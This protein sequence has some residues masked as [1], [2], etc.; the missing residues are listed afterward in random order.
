MITHFRLAAAVLLVAVVALEAQGPP[1]ATR[2]F[3]A[4]SA[5]ATELDRPPVHASELR[6]L[7]DRFS[8]DRAAILRFY[9]IPG[10][11][12][13]RARMH[14]FYGGWQNALA[15]VNFDGL[16][17]EGRVDFVLLRTKVD[18][19][20]ALVAREDRVQI[21][22]GPLVPFGT[23]IVTLAE[24]RQRLDFVKPDAAAKAVADIAVKVAAA[25]TA[26]GRGATVSPAIAVR[27]AQEVDTLAGALTQWFN[28]F[29]GYDPGF[30]AA[31]PKPYQDLSQALKTYAATLREKL[32]G[33]PPGAGQL[34]AAGGRGAG[35]GAPA[36]TV[37][38]SEGPIV[39]DPIG[40]EGLFEDLRGEMIAYTPEQLIAI[41]NKEAEWTTAEMKRASR[42]MGFGDDWKK[43]LEKVKST[44]VP[45]GE[46]PALVR[47]LALQAIAFVKQKDLVTI[48]P[49]A[50]DMWRMTMMAPAQMRVNPY[51]LGGETIQ[52]S[53]PTDTMSAEDS[54]M[55]MRG[56]GPH[57]SHATVFHE[58]IPGH[59]LQGF[60][61]QRYNAHRR[62]FASPFVTEGWAL[63]WEYVM[64]D[65]GFQVSPEDRIGALFWRM[66][67]SARIVFSLNF[68]LGR[69]TPEQ[70]VQYL[71]DQVG[72]DRFTAEGE[73]RRSF[74]GSYSPLYQVGYMMG[75]LQIRAL[76]K[77]LVD[78]KKMT[79]KQFNDAFLHEGEMPIEM[80]RA[81]LT[82]KP[83]TRNYNASW[84]FYG[85][86]QPAKP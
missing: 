53:Y 56:N 35:P 13:R 61:A 29:N 30:T 79:L 83:L 24:N 14:A 33:L 63:Y 54:L 6:D 17:Q 48:P 12:T 52:V 43:A 16:S 64:W 20:D 51:F 38:A 44:Y 78:S 68:H 21:Q 40:R 81:A 73:V 66:H 67:R 71:V 76:M 26:A 75:A 60:M 1:T 62:L 57:L 37:R 23:D 2:T 65:Q 36:P 47:N 80:M 58:L 84:Q 70:C 7:V 50:E 69:W 18:Y 31:V 28:F 72:H 15:A 39:G 77:E 55:V 41:G 42:E 8:N 45:R 22:I 74:N 4:P 82:G 11:A 27:A 46:Q 10:S 5:Y 3:S 59:E 32:G 49:L 19:E 85:D 86:V 34:A 25:N 9:T